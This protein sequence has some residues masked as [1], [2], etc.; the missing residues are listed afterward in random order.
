[1][2]ESSYCFSGCDAAIYLVFL[3]V[4]A[5]RFLPLARRRARIC[6]PLLV[7]DLCLNPWSLSRF[8]FDG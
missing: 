4:T 8:R 1:M 5:N 3:T 2:I 6:R 7:D